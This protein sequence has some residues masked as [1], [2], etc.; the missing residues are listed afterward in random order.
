MNDVGR[1]VKGKG[2]SMTVTVNFR[3][4]RLLVDQ[5]KREAVRETTKREAITQWT[6]LARE[7]LLTRYPI[8]AMPQATGGE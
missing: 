2:E 6:D 4:P 7:A 5:L 3:L 8:K 1:E